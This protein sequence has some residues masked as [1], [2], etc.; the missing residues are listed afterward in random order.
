MELSVTT[1]WDFTLIENISRYP[2]YEF[3]G[4]MAKNPVGGGRPAVILPAPDPGKVE[5]YVQ[6]VHKKGIRFNYLLNAQCMGNVEYDKKRHRH[7]LHHIE[8]LCKTG[9]DSVT[10]TIPYLIQIIKKQFPSLKIKASVIAAI[11]SVQRAKFFEEMGVDEINLDYMSNRDFTFLKKVQKHVKCTFVLLANDICLF[12]CPYRSYHYNTTAHA[13]QDWCDIDT[14]YIDYCMINCTLQFLHD[15]AKIIMA[16]WIRPEDTGV[17][18]EMG[19]TRFKIGGR[20]MSTEWLTR[21]VKAYSEKKYNG[22]LFDILAAIAIKKD[23]DKN[24]YCYIDNSKLDGF[25]EKFKHTDC[26]HIC[27]E[28]DYCGKI[29][30]KAV[31]YNKERAEYFK[32]IF[33]ELKEN[34]IQSTYFK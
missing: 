20:N 32:K 2:V 33:S 30:K 27:G 23:P 25:I 8:W 22:N 15:P 1:N 10:V 24:I 16:R 6:E 11:G 3:L 5:E 4:A 14:F 29:A 12:Q 18:E 9:V 19:F 17:Y 31:S 7:L 13:S 28:C 21:A 26:T 34:M